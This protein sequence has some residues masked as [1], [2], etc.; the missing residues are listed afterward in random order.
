MNVGTTYTTDYNGNKHLT[1]VQ[2]FKSDY[3]TYDIVV[4]DR[5][6]SVIVTTCEEFPDRYEYTSCTHTF[7]SHLQRTNYLDAILNHKDVIHNSSYGFDR[8][9]A[10]SWMIR[11]MKRE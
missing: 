1:R 2:V 7:K 6:D 9:P 11:K 10:G 4:C 8:F 3:I 5:V